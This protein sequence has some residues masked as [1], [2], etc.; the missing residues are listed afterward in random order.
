M[1]L[2]IGTDFSENARA[3]G[4]TAA[5]LARRWSDTLALAHVLDE[6]MSQRLP[7]EVRETLAASTNDRLHS[8]AE[9]L[10]SDGVKVEEHMLSGAP[11]QA[12]ADLATR[13]DARLLIVSSDAAQDHSRLGREAKDR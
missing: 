13:S 3:A 7:Q 12:L 5:A 11:E 4:I 8:E 6:S 9:Q 1:K 10:S 2:V